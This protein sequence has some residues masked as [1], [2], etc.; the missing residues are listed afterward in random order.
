MARIYKNRLYK[1]LKLI[2]YCARIFLFFRNWPW[3]L[4]TSWNGPP[5]HLHWSVTEREW[6]TFG[7]MCAK[8]RD[9]IC[10]SPKS[11]VSCASCQLN[12]VPRCHRNE[13]LLVRRWPIGHETAG[14]DRNAWDFYADF[15]IMVPITPKFTQLGIHTC[16]WHIGFTRT[17]SHSLRLKLSRYMWKKTKLSAGI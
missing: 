16:Y 1:V 4:Y 8:A 14:L 5:S 9:V 11:R 3:L 12:D 17:R 13:R 15:Y 7:E 6:F 10:W 2:Q